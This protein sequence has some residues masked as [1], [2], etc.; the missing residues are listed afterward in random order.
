MDRGMREPD[1]ENRTRDSATECNSRDPGVQSRTQD[2]PPSQLDSS[3]SSTAQ[4]TMADVIRP[5]RS[6][7]AT[8]CRG[9]KPC[10]SPCGQQE[11]ILGQV[12]DLLE[13]LLSDRA[14]PVPQG[15]SANQVSAVAQPRRRAT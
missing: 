2:Q 5:T 6:E 7:E 10:R 1:P 3:S 14:S 12:E 15:P 9:R 13:C 8:P 4:A 11:A